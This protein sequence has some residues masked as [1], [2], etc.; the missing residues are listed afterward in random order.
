MRGCTRQITVAASIFSQNNRSFLEYIC[1]LSYYKNMIY[2]GVSFYAYFHSFTFYPPLLKEIM[3]RLVHTFSYSHLYIFTT[4]T[5]LKHCI[6]Q[7]NYSPFL[8]LLISTYKLQ[9]QCY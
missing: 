9:V 3:F 6:E 4:S 1:I 7:K 8:V 2:S 5:Q